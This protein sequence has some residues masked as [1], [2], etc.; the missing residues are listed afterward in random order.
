MC[1][2]LWERI[3]VEARSLQTAV[4][5]GSGWAGASG[6]HPYT[7]PTV[8]HARS[9]RTVFGWRT[10]GS[11]Q[12]WEAIKTRAVPDLL[13]RQNARVVFPST[14]RF[15]NYGKDKDFYDFGEASLWLITGPPAGF[16]G[17]LVHAGWAWGLGDGRVFIM[18]TEN[19]EIRK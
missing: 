8:N 12:D 5:Q 10:A 2:I 19:I 6:N 17:G 15:T 11:S 4:G 9:V 7:H 1:G 16:Q 13:R 14:V 3:H 18:G